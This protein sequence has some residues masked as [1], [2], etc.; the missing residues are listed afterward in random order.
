MEGRKSEQTEESSGPQKS[1]P[2]EIRSLV[3]A[4]RGES[5]VEAPKLNKW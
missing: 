5:A 2:V 1:G 3:E 4:I